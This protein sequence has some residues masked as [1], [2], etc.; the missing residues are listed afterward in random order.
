MD[1]LLHIALSPDPALPWES[2]ALSLLLAFLLSSVIAQVYIWTHRGLSYS[3]SYI[4]ALVLGA[5]VSATLMLAIGNN[6]ARGLGILGTL[7]II[8][9]RSTMKDPRDMVF[10]FSA[11]AVGTA[12]GMRSY[13]AALIGTGMFVGAAGVLDVSAFG[14]RNRFDGLVRLQVPAEP[15]VDEEIRRVLGRYCRRWVL[16]ALRE[17]EQGRQAEYNYHVKLLDPREHGPLV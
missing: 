12:V 14:S 1:E 3:R 17:V 7:A 9:F 4:Q 5:I 2:V 13:A 15:V 16:I 8:R 10:V 11:L 6:L